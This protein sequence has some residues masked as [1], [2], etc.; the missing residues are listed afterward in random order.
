M[1]SFFTRIAL[2]LLTLLTFRCLKIDTATSVILIYPGNYY[3][4]WFYDLL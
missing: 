3:Q 4:A 2:F 1:D